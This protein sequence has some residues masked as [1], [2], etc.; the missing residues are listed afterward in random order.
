MNGSGLTGRTVMQKQPAFRSRKL[1]DLA[2]L[3]PCRFTFP[4]ECRGD[5]MACHANWQAW[6]KG[7]HY[8]APDWAFAAG[9]LTAHNAIDNKLDKTLSMEARESEWMNAY[10]GTMNYLWSEG[11]IKIA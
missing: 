1:T 4:H 5:T 11:L 8:K 7:V 2:R 6:G 10:V 3:V 9:C